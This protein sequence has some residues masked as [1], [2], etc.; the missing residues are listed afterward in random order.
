MGLIEKKAVKEYQ[1]TVLPGMINEA[2][3]LLGYALPIEYDWSTFPMDQGAGMYQP[4]S[5]FNRS[6]VGTFIEAVRTLGG[7]DLSKEAMKEGLKKVTFKWD[8]DT[9]DARKSTFEGGQL[10]IALAS[11][12]DAPHAGVVGALVELMSSKL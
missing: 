2:H 5:A 6:F 12:G 1:D 11:R 9:H 4:D 3:A 7:D 8:G 10:T